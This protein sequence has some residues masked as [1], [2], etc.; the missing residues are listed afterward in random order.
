MLLNLQF[1]TRLV[2]SG[3][4]TGNSPRGTSSRS[5]CITTQLR[6]QLP[7]ITKQFIQYSFLPRSIANWNN[8]PANAATAPSLEIIKQK[9][10]SLQHSLILHFSCYQLFLLKLQSYTH[11][12]TFS[13]SFK[14]FITFSYSTLARVHTHRVYKP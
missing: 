10:S 6:S 9:I 8:L 5:L 14:Y 2:F 12:I 7:V 11:A 1:S 4:Q 13:L 3:N